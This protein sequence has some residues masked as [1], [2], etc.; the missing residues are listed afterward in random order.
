MEYIVE[1][2]FPIPFILF[3]LTYRV[4]DDR[5]TGVYLCVPP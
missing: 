5:E 1:L 2:D 4:R 3:S